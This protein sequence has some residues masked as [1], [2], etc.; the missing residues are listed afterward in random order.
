QDAAGNS[1]AVFTTSPN[2]SSTPGIDANAPGVLAA[3]FSP[4]TGTLKI[5][6]SLT[7]N[8][9]AG[10]AGLS[11]SAI[12]VNTRSVLSTLTDLGGGS[13]RVKYGVVS[14]DTDIAQSATIPISIVLVDSAGNL[15]NTFST[16]PGA[17]S[18]PAIDANRPT[19]SGVTFNPTSGSLGIDEALTVTINAGESSLTAGAI[20]INAV[21]VASTLV[22]NSDNTYTLTYTVA[23]GH[24]A[25][26]D[27]AQIPISI[28]LIDVAGNSST[29]FTTSPVA[30][31]AP[32]ID[33]SRP[34]ITSVSFSPTTGIL[35]PGETITMTINASE[36]GL[37]ATAVSL[38]GVDLTSDLNADGVGI[39]TVDYTITEGDDDISDAATIPVSVQLEDT[40]G[41][42]SAEYTTSPLAANSPGIDANSPVVLTATFTP[43][44]G[45][46]KIAD[47]LTVNITA[48]EAEYT[49]SAIAINGRTITST[50]TDLG[51]GSY[52]A[53]Y[54]V[55]SGDTDI[56]QSATIPVSIVLLDSAGNVSN[57]FTTSPIATSTPAIDAN[58]PAIT[59]VAFNPTSGTLGIDDTL[60]VTINSGEISL[61]AGAITINAVDV[62]STLVDNGDNTYA[63]TYV[64]SQG[65]AA[66][67]D[68]AQIPISIVLTD[69]AGN[70]N[71]AFTTSPVATSAPAIDPA[72]P[73]ISG[74]SFSPTSGVLTTGETLTATITASESGLVASAI[75][76]NGVDV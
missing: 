69:A 41:N 43:T 27:N 33:P 38:N 60:M 44:T 3:V 19:I 50:L 72:R 68:N 39:Y 48:D 40:S 11:G 74:V 14:G 75:T 15:S 23:E 67:A 29:A 58:R 71:T 31:S 1:S 64:V 45:T 21:D 51:S 6:D 25:I 16:S 35:T 4:T 13:Y 28:V 59:S 54:G 49:G 8:I 66:V 30:T 63:L 56:A 36:G 76:V 61:I 73:T 42:T 37:V 47:T 52:R 22:D 53:K 20:T 18:T 55:V 12:T 7:V 62:A 24:T 34:T 65:D 46:L 26:A 70:S 2:A 9:T 57:S 10:E 17:T 32:A 5:A